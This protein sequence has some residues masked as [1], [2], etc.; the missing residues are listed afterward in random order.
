MAFIIRMTKWFFLCIDQALLFRMGL[1]QW[2]NIF[3]SSLGNVNIINRVQWIVFYT[4]NTLEWN[5]SLLS[6][7]FWT[8]DFFFT[9]NLCY[10]C[11]VHAYAL[12]W[13]CLC[14]LCLLII[15]RRGV[16]LDECNGMGV[17]FLQNNLQPNQTTYGKLTLSQYSW[18]NTESKLILNYLCI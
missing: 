10:Y 2:I 8:V 11:M 9:G 3:C 4:L 15:L 5:I 13:Y 16:I 17:V 14:A 7:H 6:S 1:L 18:M 12:F